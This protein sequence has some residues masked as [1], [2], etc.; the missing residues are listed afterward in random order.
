[1]GARGHP[2]GVISF[3]TYDDGRNKHANGKRSD[4]YASKDTIENSRLPLNTLHHSTGGIQEVV[5]KVSRFVLILKVFIVEP[6]HGNIPNF[7]KLS[8]ICGL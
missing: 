7:I 5:E 6:K 3:E 4:T 1:M 2:S 8:R